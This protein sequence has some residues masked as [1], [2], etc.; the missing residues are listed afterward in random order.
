MNKPKLPKIS[1]FL[2][3]WNL[4][5]TLIT[6][7]ISLGIIA[8]VAVI[9]FAIISNR[10]DKILYEDKVISKNFF[11][12]ITV[13]FNT[14]E[15]NR[16]GI[17]GTF[18]DEFEIDET[19]ENLIFSS[20][21]E[22]S[23]FFLDSTYEVKMED[24]VAHITNNYQTKRLLFEAE[25]LRG[26]FNYAEKV[27]ELGGNIYL[28]TFDT[29][30]RTK[31][32]YEYLQ[33]IEWIKKVEIDKVVKIKNISDE[34]QTLYGNVKKNDDSEDKVYGVKAMGLDNFQNII[35][36]NGNPSEVIVSTIGY[37]A[38]IENTYFA[39]RISED[40]YN[41][42]N[43]NKEI[44]QT[45][46]QGSRILEVIQESTT[47]NV[48]ILPIVVVN[49]ENYTTI[50]TIIKAINYAIEKSNVVDYE[51]V[52]KQDYMI[53]LILKKAFQENVPI[54]AV[55]SSETE[56]NY[57]ADNSTTIAVSSIDKNEKIANFSGSGVFVDFASFSTDVEEIFDTSSNVS[58]WS[59]AQYSN[60]QI[61]SAIALIK[62]YHKNY[63]ILEV[64]NMLR[65]Y[66][67][68]LGKTGKDEQYGYG[69][70]N[71]SGLKI[72]DL[73]KTNPILSNIVVDN[74][75]WEK[76]KTIKI[77]GKDEIRIMGWAI[78]KVDEKPN[79]WT[80]LPTLSTT[81]DIA[82]T[83]EENGKYNI[84]ISDSAGNTD[85][86]EIEVSKID[87]IEP[88]IENTI[89]T[90]KLSTEKFVQ[91]N[92][93]ATDEESGLHDSPFSWDGLA[94]GKENNFL[95]VTQNGTYTV[96]VKDKMENIAK[97]DIEIK[98]FT[99]DTTPTPTPTE[100]NNGNGRYVIDD[101]H[102]IK[103]I[104]LSNNWN[105][106]INSEVKITFRN[107]LDIVDWKITESSDTP[108]DFQGNNE[109]G[110]DEDTIVNILNTTDSNTIHGYSNLTITVPLAANRQY[111]IWVKF[112]NG[113]VDLQPFR[114]VR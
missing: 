59:G 82:H 46:E 68:D 23:K 111:Y 47:R 7:A 38:A 69:C 49:E 52:H 66:S 86:K 54:C 58:K 97:K 31:E 85:K 16:D 109:H 9:I 90:S 98:N 18:K 72:S 96:Y 105:E 30:K 1:N 64:Y 99:T 103:S 24:R 91:I 8:I 106:N 92:I 12:E 43:D 61:V 21:E 48:K 75:K 80:K 70:P 6:I 100:G 13:N 81:I 37:G 114:I 63:T 28:I 17:K 41:F 44:K 5:K 40:R 107:N 55:T 11:E 67:K 108:R 88:K 101:G 110:D 39:N 35:Q 26:K 27:E 19:Q 87:K 53:D 25:E 79:E 51:L 4:N 112:S 62:T 36:E 78:T 42:F 93:T 73:D 60:A 15:T 34:S 50:S 77:N 32:A 10:Q 14:K 29:Q 57:P 89:D 74:E 22:F 45:V 33:N 76:T 113:N 104:E 84:W 65:N 102:L 56:E 2:K 94:W 83:I 71:F 3:D 20:L 95:K